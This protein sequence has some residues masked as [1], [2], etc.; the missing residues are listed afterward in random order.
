M[1]K[2]L[3]IQDLIITAMLLAIAFGASVPFDMLIFMAAATIIKGSFFLLDIGSIFD[4]SAG[5]LLIIS[6]FVTPPL[7]ILY[8]FIFLI[9]S[10]GILSLFARS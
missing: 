7:I 6:F 5:I 4:V 1:V 10:K 8:I 3:G 2:F 9:G